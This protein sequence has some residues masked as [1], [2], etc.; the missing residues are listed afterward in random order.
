MDYVLSI[1]IRKMPKIPDKF[2]SHFS[3]NQTFKENILLESLVLLYENKKRIHH[4]EHSKKKD[5]VH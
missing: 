5:R 2:N 1:G 3:L 4:R